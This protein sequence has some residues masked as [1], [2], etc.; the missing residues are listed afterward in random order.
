MLQ[1]WAIINHL[2]QIVSDPK[3]KI[4]FTWYQSYW[5]LWE[6]LLSWAKQIMIEWVPHDVKCSI[7]QVKWYSSHIW[8]DDL[9]MYLTEMLNYKKWAKIAL[10]HGWDAREDL[11]LQIKDVQKKVEVIVPKLYD[12]VKV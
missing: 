12:R 7:V 2:K 3:A 4:I 10:T 9:I 11:A 1:W 5:T 8:S 6:Q